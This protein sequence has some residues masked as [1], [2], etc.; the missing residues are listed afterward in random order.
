[1][2]VIKAI[3]WE[4][5]ALHQLD[6]ITDFIKYTDK[7]ASGSG[8]KRAE[9]LVDALVNAVE[10]L[11]NFP[12]SNPV[13][14]GLQTKIPVRRMLVSKRYEI[15]YLIDGNQIIHIVAVYHVKQARP[16]ISINKSRR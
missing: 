14:K 7:S 8:P 10:G 1:M 9:Q 4:R 15:R 13:D 5:Y 11:K 3:Q 6:T 16:S 2:H 12:E